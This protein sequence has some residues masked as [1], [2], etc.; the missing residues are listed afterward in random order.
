[1][2]IPFEMPSKSMKILLMK[3]AFETPLTKCF[4]HQDGAPRPEGAFN[5]SMNL[6][7]TMDMRALTKAKT[8]V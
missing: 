7:K 4:L 6:L 8:K 1:M 2:K 3:T 5:V